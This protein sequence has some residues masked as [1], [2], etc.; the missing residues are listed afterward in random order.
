MDTSLAVDT[1]DVDIIPSENGNSNGNNNHHGAA[2]LL[3]V[4]G[5]FGFVGSAL[6][7]LMGGA[8]LLIVGHIPVA[9]DKTDDIITTTIGDSSPSSTM[10]VSVPSS[11]EHYDVV[12]D[13]EG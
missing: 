6:G 4:W 13:D 5:V 1:L 7:P 2:Q 11:S 10:T 9:D 3:G 8:L 12:V